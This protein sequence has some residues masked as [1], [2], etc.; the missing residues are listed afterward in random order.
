M[1]DVIAFVPAG[2]LEISLW[3]S[4]HFSR[5]CHEMSGQLSWLVPRVLCVSVNG[6]ELWFNSNDH[7][8]P[9]FHAER[10]GDWEV[11]VHFM[12]DRS[13]MVEV[14]YTA[15]PRHPSKRELRTLLEQSETHR[16]ALLEE[17]EAKVNIKGPGAER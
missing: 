15:R 7:L 17:F 8:P 13:E 9:H 11:K 6:I 16:V 3:Q 5:T 12:R 2:A 14:V 1:L 10:L 4:G